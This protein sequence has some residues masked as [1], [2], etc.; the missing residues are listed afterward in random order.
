MSDTLISTSGCTE[1]LTLKHCS[2]IEELYSAARHVQDILNNSYAAIVEKYDNEIDM[3]IRQ[4]KKQGYFR[5]ALTQITGKLYQKWDLKGSKSRYWRMLT[6]HIYQQYSSRYK[7]KQIIRIIKDGGYK[8]VCPELREELRENKLFPRDVELLNIFKFLDK[9]EEQKFV[10]SPVPLD[11]TTG[12]STNVHQKITG[13]KVVVS[14]CLNRKQWFEVIY[15]IPPSIDQLI[16][17]ITKPVLSFNDEG[18]LTLRYAVETVTPISQGKNILGVD[19]GKVKKFS[20][21]ALSPSGEYSQELSP[22]KELDRNTRKEKNLS[23]NKNSNYRKRERIAALIKGHDNPDERLVEKYEALDDE[24][25]SIRS[26]LSRLKEHSSWLVARDVVIHALEQDCST[27]QMEKLSWVA[28]NDNQG[29]WD[30]SQTQDR[31][32]HKAGKFGITTELVDATY[33]SWEYPEP[34]TQNPSPLAEYDPATRELINVNGDRI[35]KDYAASIAIA[36]RYP[37]SKCKGKKNA[38]KSRKRAIQPKRCRDKNT[39]TSKRAHK[40]VIRKFLDKEKKIIKGLMD[41][42]VDVGGFLVSLSRSVVASDSVA[43]DEHKQPSFNE[44]HGGS[45]APACIT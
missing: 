14:F 17:R 11:F 31:V 23:K 40:K 42:K 45:G 30:F 7:R 3:L 35:D 1:V 8:K 27:I 13:D 37:L 26:K 16:T 9:G 21:V 10:L 2:E 25:M 12:D 33:T 15:Q 34:Y 24:Y 38:G 19:L 44:G 4:G 18:E 36:A 43:C 28:D 5:D 22:G 32:T 29:K 41:Q 6:S 20:S 39:P